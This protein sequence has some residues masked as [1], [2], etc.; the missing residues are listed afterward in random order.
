MELA[1]R[2]IANEEENDDADGQLSEGAIERENAS[3]HIQSVVRAFLARRLVAQRAKV[4]W[5]RGTL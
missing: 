4:T 2:G 3:V 5:Q 1:R